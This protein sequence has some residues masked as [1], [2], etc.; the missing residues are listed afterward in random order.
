M[1][2]CMLLAPKAE[3]HDEDNDDQVLCSYLRLS[4]Y[5]RRGINYDPISTSPA[6]KEQG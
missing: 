1:M 5:E 6:A 2:L 4:T 3:I